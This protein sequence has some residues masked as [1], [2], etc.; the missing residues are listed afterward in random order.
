MST[1]MGTVHGSLYTKCRNAQEQ[2]AQHLLVK[3]PGGADVRTVQQVPLA[4]VNVNPVSGSLAIMQE[5]GPIGSLRFVIGSDDF[6]KPTVQPGEVELYSSDGTG[7]KLARIQARASGLIFIGNVPTGDNLKAALTNLIQGIQGM[8]CVNG[9]PPVDT[10][11]KIAL[12]LTQL[13]YILDSVVS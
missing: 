12:A 3:F 5:S 1:A 10:T 9:S 7:N 4:G 8:T 13:G 11:T 2:K 6:I